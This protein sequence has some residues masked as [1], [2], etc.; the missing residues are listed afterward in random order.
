MALLIRQNADLSKREWRAAEC[1]RCTAAQHN[2][3][4]DG[5]RMNHKDH[6][7]HEE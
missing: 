3:S 1:G 7:E 5:R 2:R 6:K 4:R